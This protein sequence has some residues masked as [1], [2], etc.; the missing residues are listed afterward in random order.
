MNK[1][2]KE[3]CDAAVYFLCEAVPSSASS[4]LYILPTRRKLAA[5]RPNV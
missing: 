5:T 1:I 3:Y 4:V 2:L